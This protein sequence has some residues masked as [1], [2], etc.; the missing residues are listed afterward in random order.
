MLC[1]TSRNTRSEKQRRRQLW[2]KG[3][4]SGSLR[5]ALGRAG[6]VLTSVPRQKWGVRTEWHLVAVIFLAL[7][8]SLGASFLLQNDSQELC[9]ELKKENKTQPKPVPFQ[10]AEIGRGVRCLCCLRR[11]RPDRMA[12]TGPGASG[13]VDAAS[14]GP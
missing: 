1:T 6:A 3:E 4:C 9:Q 5:F 8:V 13:A 11:G 14:H 7:H 2:L 10:E 12:S